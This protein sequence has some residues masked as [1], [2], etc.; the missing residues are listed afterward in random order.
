MYTYTLDQ[1]KARKA[2]ITYPRVIHCHAFPARYALPYPPIAVLPAKDNR[3][4]NLK[5]A[6][7]IM[8]IVNIVSFVLMIVLKG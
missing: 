4:E 6:L 3:F 2:K 8:T 5:T 1:R 7:Q